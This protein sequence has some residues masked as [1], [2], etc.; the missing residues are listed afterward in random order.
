GLGMAVAMPGLA[1][2]ALLVGGQRR[3]GGG[4]F[5]LQAQALGFLFLLALA[6]GGFLGAA[7]VLFGQALLLGQVAQARFLEL[8]QDLGA[9]VV[10]GGRGLGCGVFRLG[11]TGLDQGDLLAHDDVHRRAVLA[12][13]DGEFLLAAAAEGDLLR[14]DRFLGGLAGLA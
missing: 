8:A 12:P 3:G 5:G 1:R 4:R 9:L 14:C 11:R 10:A 7:L 6:L 13:A 2:R